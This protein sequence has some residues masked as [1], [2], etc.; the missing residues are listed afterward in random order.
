MFNS[1]LREDLNYEQASM[2][3]DTN[4]KLYLAPKIIKGLRV[5][6]SIKV[7]H[8]ESGDSTTCTI[9]YR[10]KDKLVVGS[11]LNGRE[12][13]ESVK[14]NSFVSDAGYLNYVK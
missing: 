8:S 4:T 10:T 9:V 7:V 5:K 13:M 6:G 2:N 12:I 1:M 14:I 11:K 3:T